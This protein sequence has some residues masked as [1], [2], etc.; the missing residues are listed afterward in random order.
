MRFFS[1]LLPRRSYEEESDKYWRDI[2][3]Q[4]KSLAILELR[5]MKYPQ[6]P[7]V[8]KAWENAGRHLRNAMKRVGN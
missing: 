3:D 2:A 5:D 4:D 6:S 8:K 1:F 7:S